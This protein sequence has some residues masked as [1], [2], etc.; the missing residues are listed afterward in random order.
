MVPI[1]ATMGLLKEAERMQIQTAYIL[2]KSIT[3]TMAHTGRSKSVVQ[4]WVARLKAGQGLQHIHKGGRKRLISGAAAE[5]AVELL[6]SGEHSGSGAVAKELH[7]TGDIPRLVSRNTL[8]SAAREEAAK[9]GE[10]LRFTRGRP[11]KGLTAANMQAR[12]KFAHDNKNMD[13]TRVMFTDRKKFSFRWPGSKVS[14]GRWV[15]GQAQPGVFT[16]SHPQCF[17]LYCGLTVH[18]MTAPHTVAGTSK[19]HSTYKTKQGKPAK[20]ITTAE[21]SDVL[22]GTLLKQGQVLFKGAGVTLWWFQQD[23]DPTHKAAPAVIEGFGKGK[24]PQVVFLE[25]WPA[26]SP[27]LNPIEN[28]WGYVQARVDRRGCNS[29]DEFKQ[30][31]IEELAAVPPDMLSR[32]V[33]SMKTRL[34]LVIKRG[35]NK[36]GY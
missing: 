28:V 35:G 10:P 21:Y 7:S 8:I 29:F 31:V 14:Q 9:S 18:G 20:N 24:R 5:K 4:R 32:L 27:D 11:R 26:N 17:N 15:R 16:A 13:W 12:L 1:P 33:S 25:G 34:E 19:H 2:L 22:K 6:L 30:A 3:K 36:T 23:N